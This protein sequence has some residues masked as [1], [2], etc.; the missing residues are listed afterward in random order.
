[1]ILENSEKSFNPWLHPNIVKNEY[2]YISVFY[3]NVSPSYKDVLTIYYQSAIW[4][5]SLKPY[6]AGIDQG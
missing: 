5:T 2:L 6:S 3:L 4:T 1:M